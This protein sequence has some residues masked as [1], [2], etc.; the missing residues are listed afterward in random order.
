LPVSCQFEKAT[1]FDE[2][3]AQVSQSV[4]DCYKWQEYFSW[5]ENGR[6]AAKENFF[7]VGFEFVEYAEPLRVGKVSFSMMRQTACV[8]R[9]QLK[10]KCEKRGE[11]LRAEFSYDGTMYERGEIERLAEQYLSL[12][13]SAAAQP[14]ERLDW[15]VDSGRRP[16][17]AVLGGARISAAR[18]PGQRS[19]VAPGNFGDDGRHC[20][21]PGC[22]P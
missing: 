15:H 9:Y 20:R 18:K 10:L 3:L 4:R 11:E 14:E 2:V 7:R 16:G 8:D 12:V 17:G 19:G 21:V 22:R 6:N 1:T 13:A 5:P